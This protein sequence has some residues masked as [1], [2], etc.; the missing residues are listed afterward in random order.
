[1]IRPMKP[2]ALHSLDAAEISVVCS[3]LCRR[4]PLA[5]NTTVT[6]R[7]TCGTCVSLLDLTTKH[8]QPEKENQSVV[9]IHKTPKAFRNQVQAVP[10]FLKKAHAR[11]THHPPS[12]SIQRAMSP[13]R[14]L[15]RC[16]CLSY[17]I[18]CL[19]KHKQ[20]PVIK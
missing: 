18:Y 13:R 11:N 4:E 15:R 16:C 7:S 9:V 1:V 6:R 10:L 19:S 8:L 17:G 5:A 14:F 20:I 3:L 12:K 2:A